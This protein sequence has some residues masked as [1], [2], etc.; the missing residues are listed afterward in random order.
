[1]NML[2]AKINCIRKNSIQTTTWTCEIDEGKNN[3]WSY[4]NKSIKPNPKI[5]QII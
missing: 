1:M 2:H 3:A 4:D 5:S